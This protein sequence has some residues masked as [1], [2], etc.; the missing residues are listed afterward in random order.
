LHC[1]C[2]AAPALEGGI[3]FA[4]LLP[5]YRLVPVARYSHPGPKTAAA[6]R[7]T[8]DQ[9]AARIR[10]LE[11]LAMGVRREQQ[12]FGQQ[13]DPLELAERDA[14]LEG[15]RVAATALEAA[16]VPLTTAWRRLT[17]TRL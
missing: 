12:S 2:S 13:V 16:R 15:L 10:R 8:L 6:A 3:T 1:G 5:T 9:L 4:L 17:A 11:S 7:M 14:Y